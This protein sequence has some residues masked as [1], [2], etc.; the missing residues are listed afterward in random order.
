MTISY[1]G[2]QGQGYLS[3]IDYT[4]HGST[5]PTN[6]VIFHLETRPDAVPMY[7]SH[8]LIKTAKRLKTI[9]VRANNRLVRAYKLTYTSSAGTSR[10]LLRSVTQYGKD[11]TIRSGSITGG[12]ALPAVS[13][14]YAGGGTGF[15][16]GV[17]GPAWSNAGGWGV[18]K[19]YSTIRYPDLNGDGKA[20]HSIFPIRLTSLLEDRG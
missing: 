11:A 8:F 2:D 13:M 3:R 12:S 4:G 1:T 6:S 15:L 19:H 18:S 20:D 9:E 16:T 7:T 10:S 17:R 14:T 5:R